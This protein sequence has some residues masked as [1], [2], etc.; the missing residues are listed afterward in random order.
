MGKSSLSPSGCG[1]KLQ[2]GCSLLWL[3]FWLI[4]IIT[5]LFVA[6]PN[7]GMITHLKNYKIE[8][9]EIPLLHSRF[10][11][12]FYSHKKELSIFIIIY[13][14]TLEKKCILVAY[15]K[16]MVLF[17]F[18]SNSTLLVLC[19]L[20]RFV[21]CLYYHQCMILTS[22]L[23]LGFNL[24]VYSICMVSVHESICSSILS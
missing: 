2:S 1:F 7:Q 5:S 21:F 8:E 22:Y 10:T 18:S 3:V 15:L 17:N 14:L 12:L 19:G 23:L 13:R 16:I 6:S 11:Y 20:Q 24:W 9:L 4:I